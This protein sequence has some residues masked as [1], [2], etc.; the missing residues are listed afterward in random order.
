M[1]SAGAPAGSGAAAFGVG[2][3]VAIKLEKFSVTE[4]KCSRVSQ[5]SPVRAPAVERRLEDPRLRRA[6]G[7]APELACIYEY[8]NDEEDAAFPTDVYSYHP[9]RAPVAAEARSVNR[10][11]GPNV[12]VLNPSAVR[13][14]PWPSATKT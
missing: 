11:D 3:A 10:R 6:L 12:L 14:A 1:N 5:L 4:G 8:P 13:V 7:F 2:V 9:D